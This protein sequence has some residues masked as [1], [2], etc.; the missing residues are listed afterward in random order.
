MGTLTPSLQFD[1]YFIFFVI[2]FGEIKV[3]QNCEGKT[4]IKKKLLN[5]WYQFA[6]LLTP[7]RA[8]HVS[9][10]IIGSLVNVRHNSLMDALNFFT[11]Q[12]TQV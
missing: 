1:I 5:S 4:A 10:Q 2:I 3:M 12:S 6:Y 7:F 9:S 11:S 8:C